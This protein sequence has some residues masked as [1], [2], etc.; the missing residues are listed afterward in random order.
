MSYEEK[1]I[2]PEVQYF[3][4]VSV[5]TKDVPIMSDKIGYRIKTPAGSTYI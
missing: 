5:K 4:S 3:V 1:D 2:R